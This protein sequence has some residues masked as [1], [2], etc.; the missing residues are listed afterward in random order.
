MP[1]RWRA[2][3]NSGRVTAHVTA[4]ARI[5]KPIKKDHRAIQLRSVGIGRKNATYKPRHGYEVFCRAFCA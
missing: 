2:C 4:A 3:A 1:A 5:A